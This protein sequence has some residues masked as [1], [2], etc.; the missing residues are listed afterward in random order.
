M[1][2]ITSLYSVGDT[3]WR[4]W[5]NDSIPFSGAG[6]HDLTDDLCSAVGGC[7]TL[8]IDQGDEAIIV[9]PA[10]HAVRQ[11]GLMMLRMRRVQLPTNPDGDYFG[12]VVATWGTVSCC[13]GEA[14][15]T[16][17]QLARALKEFAEMLEEADDD[18]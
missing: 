3:T 8:L 12:W 6:L 18:E 13:R 5:L 14:Q 4:R 9:M 17:G 1:D 16:P 10:P 2:V 11:D 7:N 15:D